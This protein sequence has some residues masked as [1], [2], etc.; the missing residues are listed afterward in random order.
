MT[1][2]EWA[3]EEDPCVKDDDAETN[4]V[5]KA[6]VCPPYLE[7]ALS[8]TSNVRMNIKPAERDQAMLRKMKMPRRHLLTACPNRTK[9]DYVSPCRLSSRDSAAG[10]A[11]I[12]T[13]S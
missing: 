13:C 12:V 8:A 1:Q 9:L 5:S 10:R 2:W 3:I 7:K 6:H 4:D 11:M